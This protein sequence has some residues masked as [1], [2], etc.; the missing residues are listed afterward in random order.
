MNNLSTQVDKSFDI[1]M[2]KGKAM[3]SCYE[4]F[5]LYYRYYQIKNYPEQITSIQNYNMTQL[6]LDY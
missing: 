3:E 1:S 6:T 2:K 5:Y 4:L